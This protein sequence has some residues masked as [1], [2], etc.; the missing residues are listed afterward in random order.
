MKQRKLK[1]FNNILIKQFYEQSSCSFSFSVNSNNF[2]KPTASSDHAR[3]NFMHIFICNLKIQ[4]TCGFEY[5][6][7]PNIKRQNKHHE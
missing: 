6:D 1:F 4:K 3:D 7:K 5:G 2:A